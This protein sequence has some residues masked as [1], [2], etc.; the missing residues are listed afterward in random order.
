MGKRKVPRFIDTHVHVWSSDLQRY[1]LGE[2][3][4]PENIK[5]AAYSANDILH[6]AQPSGVDRVVLI[7]MN[8]YG[9]DNSY[10][11]E[12]IQ[13]HPI[14]FKGIAVLD[15]K[16]E[17]PEVEMCRLAGLGVRGFRLYPEE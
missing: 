8:F 6:D 2:G 10:M 16:G 11:L 1:R 12:A 15:R 7:Q 14:A 9:F 5:P 17:N 13:R 4:T 3:F